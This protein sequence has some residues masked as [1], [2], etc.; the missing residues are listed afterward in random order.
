[1]NS[2]KIEITRPQHEQSVQQPMSC[3]LKSETFESGIVP[4]K[5]SLKA[6]FLIVASMLRAV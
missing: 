3:P 4:C 1:M 2:E 5:N 6:F